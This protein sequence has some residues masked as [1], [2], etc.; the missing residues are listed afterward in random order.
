[1]LYERYPL[2]EFTLQ[3]R[4]FDLH[5]EYRGR[6]GELF[7]AL[8][9][10]YGE[11]GP[12]SQLTF[13]AFTLAVQRG[14][15]DVAARWAPRLVEAEPRF[16]S[17]AASMLTNFPAQRGMAA[18]YLRVEIQRYSAAFERAKVATPAGAE[19]S[20]LERGLTQT[21]AEY[22]R[23]LRLA[24]GRLLTLHGTTLLALG[25][26]AAAL[27]TL[28]LAF[29]A[30]WD[31]HRFLTIG[32]LHLARG[33]TAA[34]RAAFARVAVDPTTR[35][36]A[37]SLRARLGAAGA[38]PA[39]EALLA[40][41]RAIMTDHVWRAS[42]NRAP[43][44][45]RLRLTDVDGRTRTVA[46]REGTPMFIAF[47]SRYCPGS[48]AQLDEPARVAARLEGEGVPVVTISP[49][50]PAKLREFMDAE[51]YRFPVFSDPERDAAAAFDTPGFPAHFVLDG[52]GRIR[53]A[54]HDISR[55]I[56]EVAA[57]REQAL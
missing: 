27:D 50:E 5:D 11:V 2:H 33:D 48:F 53:F 39:W 28:S 20:G 35:A 46:L 44:L 14:N 57:L 10:M 45:R 3:R 22:A 43:L 54:H 16:R 37:D 21:A 41:A 51:G 31:P 12:A 40:D 42:V 9:R 1:M 25:D 6:P 38:G 47:W 4:V 32:E 8:E 56:R 55:V 13:S 49:E 30:G 19:P 36:A 7:E 17:M 23:A 18:D 15:A 34:A 26:T 29:D 52:A 24:L